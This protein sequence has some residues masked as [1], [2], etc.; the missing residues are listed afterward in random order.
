MRKFKQKAVLALTTA[1]MIAGSVAVSSPASA[2]SSPIAAC[3]GGSYHEIDHQPLPGYG[4]IYLMYDGST[5]CVVTWKTA[6]VGTPTLVGA[7]VW[8]ESPSAEDA[9]ADNYSY[10]AGPVKLNA[11]GTCI[12]W[13]GY[14]YSPSGSAYS[15]W[16]S[17]WEHCL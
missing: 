17:P 14:A 8:R 5:D 16:R 4:T 9:D 11:P 13:G 6:Y 2:A 12:M 10:Y 7:Y 1:A 15:A 3:G